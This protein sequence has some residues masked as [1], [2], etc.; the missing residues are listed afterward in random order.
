VSRACNQ[1]VVT[2]GH[3]DDPGDDR[4]V[5]NDRAAVRMPDQDNPMSLQGSVLG[6]EIVQVGGV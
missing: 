5:G 6:E 2:N 1:Q 4:S 3:R